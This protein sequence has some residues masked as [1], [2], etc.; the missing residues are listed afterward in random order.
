MARLSAQ[1]GEAVDA[2]ARRVDA[3]AV[4]Q[5]EH[6]R[7]GRGI[8]RRRVDHDGRGFRL[9][10]HLDTERGR[11]LQAPGP[12]GQALVY[13]GYQWRGRSN[14]G[15]DSELREVMLVERDQSEMSGHWFTGAYDEIGP[16][17]RLQR[18]G[19]AALLTGPIRAS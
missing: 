15:A 13:T 8:E 6:E 19:S 7:S 4:A 9:C 11:L 12:H 5:V 17:V 3:G 10:G 18:V 2:C 14:P 16:D 1:E